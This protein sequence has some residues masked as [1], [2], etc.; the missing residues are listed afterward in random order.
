MF[1]VMMISWMVVMIDLAFH[2]VCG[3]ERSV[4]RLGCFMSVIF[5]ICV[6]FIMRVVCVCHLCCEEMF[7]CHL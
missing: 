7:V 1:L 2:C 3:N 4:C 6:S 5:Y